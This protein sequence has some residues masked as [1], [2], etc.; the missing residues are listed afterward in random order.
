VIARGEKLLLFGSG[1]FRMQKIPS[2]TENNG[3]IYN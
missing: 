3:R 2:L 1:F